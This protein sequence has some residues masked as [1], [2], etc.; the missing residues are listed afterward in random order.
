MEDFQNSPIST[1]ICTSAVLCMC[2]TVHR[3]MWCVQK[4]TTLDLG[5]VD[6]YKFY[7]IPPAPPVSTI[8]WI[9]IF[10][11]SILLP[12]LSVTVRCRITSICC[13]RSKHPLPARNSVHLDVN[14]TLHLPASTARLCSLCRVPSSSVVSRVRSSPLC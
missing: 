5:S 8:L 12:P 6:S 13:N 1:D 2:V 3:S 9:F 10:P 4:R 11:S 14:H 7:Y